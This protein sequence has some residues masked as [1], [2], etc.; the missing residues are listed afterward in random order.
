YRF[1]VNHVVLPYKVEEMF[2]HEWVETAPGVEQPAS[3]PGLV[4]V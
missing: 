3:L 2:R 1:N 4:Q